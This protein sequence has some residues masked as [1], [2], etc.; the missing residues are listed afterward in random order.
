MKN[1]FNKDTILPPSLENQNDTNNMKTNTIIKNYLEFR[2]KENKDPL[3]IK[4]GLS[5][6]ITEIITDEYLK[7]NHE[8]D[9]L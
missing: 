6:S 2:Y 1:A 8:I 5:D 4:Y 7:S 9:F 3:S